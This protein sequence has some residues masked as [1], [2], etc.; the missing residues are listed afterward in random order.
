MVSFLR[1][2]LPSGHFEILTPGDCRRTGDRR[3]FLTINGTLPDEIGQIEEATFDIIRLRTVPDMPKLHM[4]MRDL[5]K[6]CRTKEGKKE[7]LKIANEVEPV[8]PGNE[9][10]D[11]RD[12]PLTIPEIDAKWAAKNKQAITYHLKKAW[13]RHETEKEKETPLGL[14]QAAY[15]KLTHD[16]MDVRSLAVIDFKKARELAVAIRD[17]ADELE[18]AIYHQEKDYKKLVGKKP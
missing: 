15:K 7:I 13:K 3:Q 12:K 9:C 16:D 5:P 6:Y 8:L 10:L 14:L 1:P 17:R 11:N 18:S 2:D 4:I